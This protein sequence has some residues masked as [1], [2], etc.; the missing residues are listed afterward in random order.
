MMNGATAQHASVEG[1]G[2]SLAG[3]LAKFKAT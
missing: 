1:L 3:F 2:R